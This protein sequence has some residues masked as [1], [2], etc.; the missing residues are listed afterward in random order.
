MT[1]L[2]HPLSPTSPNV[3]PSLSLNETSFTALIVPAEVLKWV[4]RFL[5]SS[6]VDIV[7]YTPRDLSR[8]VHINPAVRRFILVLSTC[9]SLIS[10]YNIA[11]RQRKDSVL[12]I[13]C[14]KCPN[15][16]V[17]AVRCKSTKF[18]IGDDLENSRHTSFTSLEADIGFPICVS[19][20]FQYITLHY[21]LLANFRIRSI[22]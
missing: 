1:L 5:I 15:D 21:E 3:S 4:E 13:P 18:S 11:V 12:R 2:P 7:N 6:N 10:K 8:E 14:I 20:S 22:R 16:R 9:T 17:S 19:A